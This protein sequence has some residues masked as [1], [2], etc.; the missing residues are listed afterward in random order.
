MS[1]TGKKNVHKVLVNCL[2]YCISASHFFFS[3]PT[4][5]VS[6]PHDKAPK[7]KFH[8]K[9]VSLFEKTKKN[10]KQCLFDSPHT[11]MVKEG[12][13]WRTNGLFIPKI[14]KFTKL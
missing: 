2:W 4:P 3:S 11:V 12:V 8:V 9:Y 5:E 14:A 1:V 7:E 6:V 10:N 13:D